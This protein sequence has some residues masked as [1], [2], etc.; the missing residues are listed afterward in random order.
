MD[1]DQLKQVLSSSPPGFFGANVYDDQEIAAAVRAAV[2]AEN[3]RALFGASLSD[4][5]VAH[6]PPARRKPS[7]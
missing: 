3:A 4:R 7:S 2:G 6:R 1:L 5:I